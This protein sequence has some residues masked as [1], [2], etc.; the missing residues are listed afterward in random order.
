MKRTLSMLLSGALALAVALPAAAQAEE[1]RTE[2]LGD[3]GRTI[4]EV[5]AELAAIDERQASDDWMVFESESRGLIEV[6]LTRIEEWVPAVSVLRESSSSE[7]LQGETVASRVPDLWEAS[8]LL[9]DAPDWVLGAG[10]DTVIAWLRD[11]YRHLQ[12][13]EQKAALYDAKRTRLLEDLADLQQT[14][15]FFQTETLMSESAGAETTQA[16][17]A[18]V[19]TFCRELAK[20]EM[21][22]SEDGSMTY[23]GQPLPN[24]E[25]LPDW[26]RDA[27]LIWLTGSDQPLPT[28]PAQ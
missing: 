22:M 1:I 12:T 6:D 21:L 9:A 8:V 28:P 18:E 26:C 23:M 7:Q 24:I 5:Q 2:L 17:S 27:L 4:T 19:E 15:E 20:G 25:D 13:P 11:R 10:P 14:Q 3:I 16:E